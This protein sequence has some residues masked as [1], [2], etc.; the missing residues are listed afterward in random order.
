LNAAAQAS[1]LFPRF[2]YTK[3]ENEREGQR[4]A[5]WGYVHADGLSLLLLLPLLLLPLLLLLP[6]PNICNTATGE[7]MSIDGCLRDDMVIDKQ[8]AAAAASRCALAF[9]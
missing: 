2:F 4:L 7:Q 6:P 9:C 8:G 5:L 1:P 3:K